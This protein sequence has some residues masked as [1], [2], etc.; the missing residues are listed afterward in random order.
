MKHK[1]SLIRVFMVSMLAM[2]SLPIIILS[3]LF[4]FGDY[5]FFHQDRL[6][7]KKAYIRDQEI[8]F[9]H[10]VN[11]AIDYLKWRSSMRNVPQDRLKK[12]LIEWFSMIRFQNRGNDPGF[13][14]VGTY[15]GFYLLKDDGTQLP[16][17]NSTGRHDPIKLTTHQAFMKAAQNP[18]GEF[19]DYVQLSEA[20]NQNFPKKAFVRG[21]PQFRWYIG[22]GFWLNDIDRIISQK[23]SELKTKIETHVTTAV[24]L[25]VAMILL[26]YLIYRIMMRKT[27]AGFESFS[28]FFKSAEKKSA[29]VRKQALYFSEFIEMAEAADKMIS[30]RHRAENALRDSESRYRSIIEN[31]E[32]G[33]CEVDRRGNIVYA[34]AVMHDIVGYA[35]DELLDLDS[36]KLLV[37]EEADRV[38]KYFAGV[39]ISEKTP[40]EYI[41][42]VMRKD[43]IK[44]FIEVTPSVI[45]DAEGRK[46]GIRSIV[47]DVDQR[48]KYE[49]NLIY[50][51]YHDALTGLKNRKAFYEQLQ[52]AI[53]HAKRYG[54]RIGLIYIDMDNFKKVNDTLGHEIGDLLLQEIKIRLERCLRKTDFIS[55]IGGDEFV[56]IVDNPTKIHPAV[57]AQKVVDELSKPYNLDGHEVN[58]VTASV[59]ISTFPLDAD[60]MDSLIKKADKAMYKAKEK[61]NRYYNYSEMASGRPS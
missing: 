4:V 59:G 37:E 12:E 7:L 40:S 3:G 6:E 26:Q 60:D 11:R 30:E 39:Y 53:Y 61:R 54:S 25:L 27:I 52:T 31:I 51:A 45:K 46:T 55:R 50:L 58:Y 36:S 2:I 44:K 13:L 32:E 42:P 1:R 20:S 43:G 34:N 28:E 29:T 56:I 57:V 16:D 10:E 41:F 15:D 23:K 22:S 17:E 5:Y 21:V 38:L 47:R 9:R 8:V 19:V 48:K 18:K 33:Y 49:E 35:G 24:L 14:F